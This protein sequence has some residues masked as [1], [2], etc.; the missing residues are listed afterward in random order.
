MFKQINEIIKLF[1]N[2]NL[3]L[4][5]IRGN[6]HN[7]ENLLKDKKIIIYPAGNNGQLI[8]ETLDE[9]NIQVEGF[10]DK[11]FESIKKIKDIQVFSQD[12]LKELDNNFFVIIA[13]NL[14]SQFKLFKQNALYINK[15]LNLIEGPKLNRILKYRQCL[16]KFDNNKPLDLI[17]CENCGFEKKECPIAETYLKKVGNFKEI[18][19]DTRS[20]QFDWF[21][22]IVS[23]KCT[24]KCEHCCEQVPFQTD[25]GFSDVDTIIKDVKKIAKSSKF[26]KYVELIGGEPLMHPN[27]EKLITELLKIENIG[28]IKSFTNATIVPSDK[29]CEIMINPRFMLYISDY[30]HVTKGG[31]LK[32]ILKTKEKLKLFGIKYIFSKNAEWLDFSSFKFQNTPLKVLKNGFQKCFINM[33]HRVYKGTLYRCPHQYAGVQRGQLKKSFPECIDIHTFNEIELADA[34]EKFEN[35][36]YLDACK[37]CT[38]PIGANPTPAGKQLK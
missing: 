17:E 4:T 19:N 1:E 35:L 32:S 6:K 9:Y 20:T 16:Q 7:L 14:P 28:Y 13:V 37:H 38:M 22:Y 25:K 23:Q 30:E 34:L 15:N 11:A 24:L 12:K 27:I 36:E 18:D 5:Q 3:T 26:L 33:C 10:V 31:L 29:L 2:D 21:G 8:Q